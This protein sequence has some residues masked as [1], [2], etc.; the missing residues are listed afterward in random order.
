MQMR[1]DPL[2][3]GKEVPRRF[4]QILGGERLPDNVKGSGRLE[5]ARWVSD[6]TNPLTARVLVNR[7]WLYHFGK[8]LVPTP[9]DYGKQGQPPTHPELLD[10]LASRFLDSG[11]SIKSMHRLMVTSRAY[12]QAS[13]EQDAARQADPENRLYW[14][15]DRRRLDAESIRDTLLALGGVLDR[16]VGGPHPFPAQKAWDFTQHKPFKAVYETDR[17]S[18]YLM[19]QRIQRHP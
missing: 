4:L 2:K 12:R 9:N 16:S 1:G 15:F 17:R 3:P 14:R 5:L 13:D 18:V 8:G 6:A 19:T 11:W 10:W 7:L